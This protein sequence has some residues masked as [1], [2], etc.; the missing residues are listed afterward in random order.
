[1]CF[2]EYLVSEKSDDQSAADV[3][4]DEPDQNHDQVLR[5]RHGERVSDEHELIRKRQT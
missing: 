3:R 2:C 1:M 5:E 4:E